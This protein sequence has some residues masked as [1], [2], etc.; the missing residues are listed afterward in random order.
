[1]ILAGVGHSTHLDLEEAARDASS[2]AM[3]RM[4]SSQVDFVLCFAT[5]EFASH[6]PK[7]FQALKSH[8]GTSQI[9]GCSAMAVLTEEREFEGSPGLAL[10]TLSSDELKTLPFLAEEGSSA[11]ARVTGL[12]KERLQKEKADNPLLILLTDIFNI[13]APELLDAIGQD[14]GHVPIVGAA[15]SGHPEDKATFQWAAGRHTDRGIAGVFLSGSIVHSTRI[16]Q[17]CE[18]IGEPY[19]ITGAEGRV[20]KEIGNRPAYQMLQEALAIFPTKE[21]ERVSKGILAGILYD[22]HKYP[23]KRGDYLTRSIESVDPD[24]GSITIVENVRAGQTIQFHVRNPGTAREEL[25]SGVRE[26]TWN[27]SL[28]PPLFALYFESLGRGGRVHKEP[29]HDLKII[30]EGLGDIPIIGFL[31][32]AE[33]APRGRRNLVHNYSAALTVVCQRE[34]K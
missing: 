23:P 28:R 17:G 32:N 33:F 21:M 16:S 8:T 13:R 27:S 7:L 34:G 29:D 15:S 30:R 14:L 22:E 5:T 25:E 20:I 9:V 2:M 4:G 11:V 24:S 18:P 12:L 31:S 26:I 1:M 3:E 6:Y 19:I 10:L